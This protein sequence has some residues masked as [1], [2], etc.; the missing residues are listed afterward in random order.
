MTLFDLV[1][2]E[3]RGLARLT[4][5]AVLT[6]LVAV[7]TVA[8]AA[9]VYWL[10]GARWLELPRVLP[11]TLWA[12]VIGIVVVG[13]RRGRAMVRRG[14]ELSQVAL[15]VEQE[16]ALRTGS[17]RGTLE[18][19]NSGALGRL[20]AEKM[21]ER[22]RSLD[23]PVL[24][25]IARK[26]ALTRA[27]AGCVVALAGAFGMVSS[28]T[29]APDGW[30]ALLH[31]LRAWTG[32]LLD[33]VTLGRVPAAVLRGERVTLTVRAPGRKSVEVSQ[34]RTGGAWLRSNHVVKD[35]I[36]TVRLD[37]IDA[38]LLVFATD[39]RAISDTATISVVERPFI[40][41]VTIRASF[42]A[43]LN[44]R[45]ETISLGEPARIPR[46][47]VLAL[48]GQSS[49]ELREVAL[50]R[51][52]STE[53]IAMAP[54]GRHFSGRVVASTSGRYVW[55]AVG[56]GG[57]IADVPSALDLDVQPDSEPRVEILSPGRDTTAGASDTLSLSI[58]ATDDHGVGSV[59]VRSWI[60]SARG[61]TRAQATRAIAA[62]LD[63]QWSGETPL[64]IA[65]LTPGEALHVVALAADRSPWKQVGASRELIIRLPTLTEQ[66]DA[67]RAQADSAVA[68]AAATANAQ[69]QLQQRT[70]DAAKSRQ[71]AK[72]NAMS[73]ESAEQAKNL[74]K[75]QRQLADRMQQ[76]QDAARQLEQQLKQAGALDSALQERLREA[77]KLMRDALTPELQE[78]LR[79]LEQ[80]S[81]KLSQ[82]DARKAMQ[83]LSEQQKK[84]RE[85][86]EK[87]VEMLKR[88]AIEGQMQT[89]KDEAR[90][91]AKKQRELVDSLRKADSEEERTAA[92]QQAKDLA[93]KAK[94]L[95]NDV[96]ELQ[97]R[98]KREQAE[99]GAERTAEANQKIQES[100][101]Q[102][103][104]S[105]RQQ[106]GETGQGQQ[107]GE[108][109]QGENKQGGEK[110]GSQG[111]S[112]QGGKASDKSQQQGGKQ[113]QAQ[114]KD[115]EE[116]ARQA[117]E[118]MEEAAEQLTKAREQQVSEWKKELTGELDQSIQEM[119]QLAREQDQLEQQARKGSAIDDL[120]AQQSALQQ[121]V[122][123][124][125]QR[126]QD[127]GKKSS[128]LSQR[129]LRMT[130]DARRKVEDA[131]RQTQTAQSGQQMASAM[132][133]ASEALNQAAASLVRD[134]ERTQ[135]AN[136]ATGFAEM[137]KQLQQMSQQ[138]SALN[139]AVQDLFPKPGTQL[140]QQGQ[141]EARQL[142]RQQREVAQQLD[143]AADR[144][145]SGR[146]EQMAKEA[147]QIAQAL[148][149]AQVDPAVIER[150]Q[151]L[152][153][154]MLDAGKLLEED[155]RED[156]GKREAKA[157]TG[158]DVFTPA[159]A[160]ATGKSAVRF[161]PPAW[162]EL[163]G[164][165]PEER[166]LVLEYF[167]K[168]N[169]ERP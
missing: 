46:G 62:P 3:R 148:E 118:S 39:G 99:G 28:A 77:Q 135:E 73:F 165:T 53:R 26:R 20:S 105:A 121:G 153:R 144:D 34:R 117:A 113:G 55:S 86:L 30:A 44:R 61:E 158:T 131:T 88:A 149:L 33:G 145:D 130:I 116:S 138:Q 21:A 79:K 25:P 42:P 166:R 17:L 37:P 124:A 150:Q 151:R 27:L 8:V 9:A 52:G 67:V 112:Q 102:M 13:L 48:D 157:W 155:Q 57:P 161:Q 98:L 50:S 69:K 80:A 160:S 96:K 110:Q 1:D 24:A 71:S 36:T 85:Q 103:E 22:L 89:L 97:Q 32:T 83:D 70:A 129:S 11:F 126:L 59:L 136:S 168:I 106:A 152:F 100:A 94:D 16:R 146:A 7:V 108:K 142:A 19:A 51:D 41:G 49:T 65:G 119:L 75:E 93:D 122:E 90:E 76:M 114:G 92:Q 38:T 31:P 141:A 123:K 54:N 78:Q 143:D 14:S 147:R 47:T 72:N 74:A 4:S 140:D 107:S 58:L 29:A 10:G 128:L 95:S 139:S 64:A 163:R 12:I 87:S 6:V 82:E 164:L 91:M 60:V 109:Q 154:K 15:A 137:L 23:S 66:R 2:R 127:A 104:Q 45:D 81:N 40:G 159:N 125:G 133:E 68:R 162:N 18:V 84:L 169:A 111:Q 43:Y 120:R 134:R 63:V 132:R 167:K 35:G 115:A 5:A 56:A 156:T 101:Q